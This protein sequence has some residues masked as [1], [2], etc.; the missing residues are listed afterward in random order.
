M[1]RRL[2]ECLCA[3]PL[4][5]ALTGGLCSMAY[6]GASGVLP[7]AAGA[8]AALLLPLLPSRGRLPLLAGCA[9][10][11]TTL[12]LA[13]LLFDTVTDGGKL[14]LNRLFQAS[15]AAQPYQYDR[16]PVRASGL[17]PV[18]PALLVLGLLL[19]PL[20]GWI[21][22]RV[23]PVGLLLIAVGCALMSY[24]GI[25]PAT[26]WLLLLGLSALLL[27]LPQE[28]AALSRG[29]LWLLPALALCAVLLLLLPGKDPTLADWSDRAR[30]ALALS[31]V[32][33][34]DTAEA[35]QQSAQAEADARA[36]LREQEAANPAPDAPELRPLWVALTVIVVLLLLFVPSLLS[37]RLRKRRVRA[38]TGLDDPDD[39][40]CI[41][42]SFLYALR[43]LRCAGLP[44]RNRPYSAYA[45]EIDARFPALSARY[46]AAVP[47]WQE[48]AYSTHSLTSVQRAQ[49]QDFLAAARAVAFAQMRPLARLR[50]RMTL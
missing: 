26:I 4:Y 49:M 24:L 5:A 21:A 35:P 33:D 48:A 47:L 40:V 15:E 37:D 13:L 44:D 41:R 2:I 18:G 34:A 19:G 8:G 1:P 28:G 30:D 50:C 39:R 36:F 22:R 32:Y 38:R 25:L 9:A 3:L 7:L 31:T 23:R 27:L 43:L 45:E 11:L 16:F 42:A 20:C 17:S 29:L 46:R 14:L 12:L 10:L 6:L